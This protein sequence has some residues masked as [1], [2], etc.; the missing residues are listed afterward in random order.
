MK[1]S[2]LFISGLMPVIMLLIACGATLSKESLLDAVA[3]LVIEKYE[4]ASCEQLTQMKP[5]SGENAEA[6]ESSEDVVQEKA[7]EM[8]RNNP[9]MREQFINR[10]AGPIAN[11]MFE[12]NLVP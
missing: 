5:Q 11:K 4:N 8:L 3:N 6:K 7:M 9:E 12:C 2:H 10:V 1:K